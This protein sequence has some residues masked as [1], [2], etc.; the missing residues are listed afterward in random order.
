MDKSN[1]RILAITSTLSGIAYITFSAIQIA[2]TFGFLKIE[3]FYKTDIITPFTL[4]VIGLIYLNG[5][6]GL[7]N[8]NIKSVSFPLS[9]TILALI[10]S[11]VY[12][13]TLIA[14]AIQ[15]LILNTLENWSVVQDL[16]PEIFLAPIAMTNLPPIINMI[17]TG[18]IKPI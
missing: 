7:I 16:T 17:R 6:P 14:H 18:K 9:A 8:K 3:L 12:F 11:T 4:L 5:L 2:K 10:V 13:L 1:L 15:A